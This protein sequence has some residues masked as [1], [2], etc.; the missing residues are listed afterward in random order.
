MTLRRTSLTTGGNG[1]SQ[2]VVRPAGT[3]VCLKLLLLLRLRYGFRCEGR[4][5]LGAGETLLPGLVRGDL[6]LLVDHESMIGLSLLS[7][8][9]EGDAFLRMFAERHARATAALPASN[10]HR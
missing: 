3:L 2:L 10:A 5:I 9:D 8:S 4:W 7:D 6:R 1:H